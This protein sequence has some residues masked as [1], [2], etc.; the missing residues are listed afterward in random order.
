MGPNI[1]GVLKFNCGGSI[2]GDGPFKVLQCINNNAYKLELPS[3]YS[4]V[5]STFNISDL[6][7][8]DAGD[9]EGNDSR[10]NPLEERG[11]DVNPSPS[12][13]PNNFQVSNDAFKVQEGPMTIS[14]SKKLQEALIGLI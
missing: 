1:Q 11:N 6:S 10:M 3:E 13:W 14:K 9:D 8:F 7:L 4:N 12:S 2:S 5:S